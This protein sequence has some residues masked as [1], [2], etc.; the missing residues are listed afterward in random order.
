MAHASTVSTRRRF[1]AAFCAAGIAAAAGC[2]TTTAATSPPSA[3]PVEASTGPHAPDDVNP[4]VGALLYVNPDY[5]AAVAGVEQR[6]PD[7]RPMLEKLKGLPTAVW[8]SAI[9]DTEDVSRHLERARRQQAAAGVPVA[10]VFVL[11][12]LPGRDCNAE[13]SAGEL[14]PDAAG[15]SRY[16]HQ[17]VDAIAAAFHAYPHQR[18]VAVLEPDSLSNLVTNMANPRCA[19]VADIYK[20]GIAYAIAKLSAPNVFIYLEAAH[21]G[22][23]SWPKNLVRS[24]PLY[25]QVLDMAGGADRVRGFALNVSNYDPLEAHNPT[26]HDPAGPSDDELGYVNDLAAALE[27]VGV[28]GKGF[29]V[30]TGRNGRG[31]LRSDPGSWCNVKGAGLGARPRAAPARLVD[32]YLYVKVPGESDGT[33]DSTSR[34][35]DP[36]CGSDD[37]TP[38]APE[39]GLMFDAY[40][41]GLLR[42]AEPPL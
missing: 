3:S 32:A 26:P 41:L 23:L 31:G 11:Y 34:R 2:A 40:L 39:A 19:A 16:Q 14:T 30:D 37:A 15:E 20:R 22:W 13:S 9:R 42:N 33:S 27:R 17:F 10:S 4:F 12:D 6:H 29:I 18:I 38:G 7:A 25:K 5:V 35:F 1:T 8:E 21:A 24:V 28:G 36:G